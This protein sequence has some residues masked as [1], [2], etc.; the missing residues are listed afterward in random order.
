MGLTEHALTAEVVHDLA[1]RWYQAL[2]R[3]D[4]VEPVLDF[5]VDEGLEMRF[6]EGVSRGHSGF[7]DWYSGVTRRFFDETHTLG[8]VTI[9]ST[10]AEGVNVSVVVNW[11]AKIWNPPDAQSGWIGF[12]AYQTWRVVG[13]GYHPQIQRYVVDELRAMPGSASLAPVREP[14]IAR[15][16]GGDATGRTS[17]REVIN[18]Y[19]ELASAGDWDRWCDL[20]AADQVM[21]EQLAGHVEGLETLHTMM[22][23]FPQT[24]PRFVNALKHLVVDGEEAASVSHISAQTATGATIEADA[25]N[26]F[27]VIDGR[28]AYMAN[29]HDTVPFT[30]A[31]G[32]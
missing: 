28:I 20:F 14:G 23:G 32:Q 18:H 9:T 3:H 11:Q 21:D 15:D 31:L 25:A 30:R 6:P 19:F 16:D 7:R 10:V 29:F 8:E 17:T 13:P 24:Y 2:D 12:D 4:D 22:A 5:L 27:R 26:Y 1:V